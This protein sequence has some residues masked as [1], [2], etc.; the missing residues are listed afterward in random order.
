M[1]HAKRNLYVK[2][3]QNLRGFGPPSHAFSDFGL[4]GSKNLIFTIHKKIVLELCKWA[5]FVGNG[6]VSKCYKGT[7]ALK[8]TLHC[9][10][11]QL[12]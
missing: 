11:K 8:S 9:E 7:Y 6:E 2:V 3:Q 4:G 10:N 12:L 5:H 1:M